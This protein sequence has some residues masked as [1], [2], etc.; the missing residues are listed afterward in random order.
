MTHFFSSLTTDKLI[1]YCICLYALV[2]SGSVPAANAAID[3]GLAIV[4]FQ[5][6]KERRVPAVDRKLLTVT[7]SFVFIA[8]ISSMLALLPSKSTK[9][10]WSLFY[11]ML[12][13]PLTMAYIKEE[14]QK[15]ILLRMV[16]I[17]LL[18]SSLYIF[19]Q[20]YLGF[21]RAW[22][23]TGT[24]LIAATYLELSIPLLMVI[25]LEKKSTTPFLRW[26]LPALLVCACLALILV[27]SRAAWIAVAVVMLLYFVIRFKQFSKKNIMVFATLLCLCISLFVANP[28]LLTRFYS[29]SDMQYQNNSERILMWKS[30]WHMFLDYP[31]FGVGIGNFDIP[32]QTIY[33]APEAK[34]RTVA[35]AHNNYMHYLAETGL[36]GFTSFLF[37]FIYLLRHYIIRFRNSHDLI[38]LGM[39]LSIISFM[40]HGLADWNYSMFP[41]TAQYLWFLVGVTW[42]KPKP[43]ISL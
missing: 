4:L 2:F 7:F 17:S 9:Q 37:L 3:V 41:S 12:T 36:I 38:A 1:F 6:W 21:P 16:C 35:H 28:N 30:A 29:I 10:L 14:W 25:I 15:A 26:T 23:M 11:Y 20:G 34:E 19:W 24:W 39:V 27:N 32:Y 22:G 33:I 42:Q 13:L 43:F 8:S 31:V 18:V 40:I 5:F